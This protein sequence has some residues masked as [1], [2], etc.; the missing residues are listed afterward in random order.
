LKGQGIDVYLSIKSA[1]AYDGLP[2]SAS[3]RIN[4]T[5]D[6]KVVGGCSWQNGWGGQAGSIMDRTM[7][8]DITAAA[9]EITNIL[10]KQLR[11]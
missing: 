8:K 2:Q 9:V 3:V 6:G 5:S 7:R 11:K 10:V 1:A 4:S